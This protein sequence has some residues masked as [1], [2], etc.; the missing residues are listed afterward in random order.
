MDILSRENHWKAVL[1]RDK[2]FDGAFVYGVHSTRIYCRPSCPARR[3]RPEQVSFFRTPEAAKQAGFRPCRR[4]R[5]D[6]IMNPDPQM[7]LVQRLCRYI[8]NYDSLEEPLTLAAMGKHV[9]VSPYHL[10]RIFKCN[11]G[12]TPRQYAEASRMRRLKGLFKDGKNVTSALYEAGY[13]SSSRLYEGASTRLGMT[14][15]TYMRGGKGMRIRYTIV[16]SPLGRLLVAAT[17]KGVSAVSIG[18]SDAL[19]ESAL[20]NEYPAAEIRRDEAGLGGYVG[21]LLKFVDGKQPNLNLPLDVQVTAFQWHVYEALRSIPYGQTRSY[22]EVAETIGHPK[23]VRAVAQA[24]ASNPTALIIPCHRVVRKNGHPGGYRW[25]TET[26]QTLLAKEK[27][28]AQ[29]L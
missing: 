5:P 20:F 21:A 23:A 27:L 17:E 2:G 12:I 22:A 4:C 16:H 10:Q 7:N 24:C 29:P 14:P 15:G 18:K 3:P 6:E 8:E 9:K 28:P 25:G 13:G 11:M 19:L 26:K 1:A